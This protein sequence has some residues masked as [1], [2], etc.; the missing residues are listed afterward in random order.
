MGTT[1]KCLGRLTGTKCLPFR[2]AQHLVL[3]RPGLSTACVNLCGKVTIRASEYRCVMSL[4][5][6]LS[7]ELEN[8]QHQVDPKAKGAGQ[9]RKLERYLDSVGFHV[10]KPL[11]AM[12]SVI[13]SLVTETAEEVGKLLRKENSFR[14]I[15]QK[16]KSR[17]DQTRECILR[18]RPQ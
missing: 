8:L 6:F 5:V 4:Y 1:Y 17:R 9:V 18:G 12:G 7:R 10:S 11:Q 3:L 15:S 2:L 14:E 13:V 16:D